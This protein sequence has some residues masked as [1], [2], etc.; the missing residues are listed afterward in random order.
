M[1]DLLRASGIVRGQPPQ[2][3]TC[4]HCGGTAQPVAI[5]DSRQGKNVRLLRCLDCEKTSWIEER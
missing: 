2:H 4:N 1:S 5:L 3:Q